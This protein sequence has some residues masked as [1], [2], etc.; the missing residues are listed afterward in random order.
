MPTENF[1]S[2]FSV[3]SASSPTTE[4]ILYQESSL[5]FNDIECGR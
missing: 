3:S 1:G 4:I 2:G 5:V